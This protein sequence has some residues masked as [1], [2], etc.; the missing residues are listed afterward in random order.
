MSLDTL[1]DRTIAI[2]QASPTAA[3]KQRMTENAEALS[4]EGDNQA[5]VVLLNESVLALTVKLYV[6]EEGRYVNVD[7]RTH[8]II[9]PKPWGSAGWRKWGVRCWEGLVLRKIL[10]TRAQMRRV[11]PLFDYSETGQWYLNLHDYPRLD[12][13]LAYWKAH[14][15]SLRDWR[16]FADAYREEA[17][18]RMA[19]RRS[20]SL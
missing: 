10:I 6:T 20:G 5:R 11:V 4:R 15:V 17:Q 9:I 18:A 1:F 12:N 7:H 8:R 13:A 19:R 16:L 3:I 2:R 14:P